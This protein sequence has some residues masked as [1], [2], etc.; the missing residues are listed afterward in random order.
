MFVQLEAERIEL[1]VRGVTPEPF[2]T[3][4]AIVQRAPGKPW[5]LVQG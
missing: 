2:G 4:G 5:R 1:W 3:H